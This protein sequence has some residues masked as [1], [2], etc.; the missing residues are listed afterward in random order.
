MD[1][2]KFSRV[3][4]EDLTL[5][6]QRENLSLNPYV[7]KYV[8]LIM[9]NYVHN[10]PFYMIDVQETTPFKTYKTKGDISLLLV[11]L[12]NEWLNRINRPLTEEN[13]IKTGK[14]NYENAYFYL[15]IN[16]GQA[17]K[18]E[19]GKNYLRYIKNQTDALNTYLEIFREISEYFE[20][21]AYLLKKYREQQK[22]S[23]EFLSQIPS[24]RIL[25][26]ENIISKI[27]NS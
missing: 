20:G 21:Y 17:L 18:E 15:D 3:F 2:E 16:Y 5:I 1:L 24:G 25:E 4:E 27:F 9:L 11:G 26:L 14:L 7:I 19:I 8:S 10:L 22:I 12:F 13:Y 6:N 23:S